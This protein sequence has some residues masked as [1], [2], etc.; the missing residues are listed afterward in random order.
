MAHSASE[1]V[2]RQQF[3]GPVVKQHLILLGKEKQ[4]ICLV[5]HHRHQAAAH[6]R[7]HE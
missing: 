6:Q 5:H 1:V 2:V 7:T 3:A 4:N